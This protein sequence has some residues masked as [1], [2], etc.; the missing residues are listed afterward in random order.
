M[1]PFAHRIR[2]DPGFCGLQ[3]PGTPEQAQVSLYAYDTTLVVT[4]ET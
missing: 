3:M 1:E 2:G 4:H